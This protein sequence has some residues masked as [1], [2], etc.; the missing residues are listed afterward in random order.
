ML[1]ESFITHSREKRKKIWFDEFKCNR[2]F[3]KFQGNPP[4]KNTSKEMNA[5]KLLIYLPTLLNIRCWNF[6]I[7]DCT[8][9]APSKN[10]LNPKID[11]LVFILNLSKESKLNAII[12]LVMLH[13]IIVPYIY[14]LYIS[15]PFSR[16]CF[17]CKTIER[18]R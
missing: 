16:N 11:I 6:W 18:I 14:F 13:M 9:M 7:D 4:S 8:M 15:R 5:H 2:L 12:I 17:L 3:Q 10:Q 1:S